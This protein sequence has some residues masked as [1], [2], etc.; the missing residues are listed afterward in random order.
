MSHPVQLLGQ[1]VRQIM[2]NINAEKT[3]NFFSSRRIKRNVLKFETFLTLHPLQF[4]VLVRIIEHADEIIRTLINKFDI[5][6]YYYYY[7]SIHNNSVM[8]FYFTRYSQ[9]N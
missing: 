3:I 4:Y 7:Y 1:C 6:Y 9:T 2:S 8:V 5:F